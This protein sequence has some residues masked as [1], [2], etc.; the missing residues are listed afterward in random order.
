MGIV[1]LI[2]LFEKDDNCYSYCLVLIVIIVI[3]IITIT[4]LATV[5]LSIITRLAW[6]PV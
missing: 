4:V 3:M 5:R 1:K 2:K 6:G